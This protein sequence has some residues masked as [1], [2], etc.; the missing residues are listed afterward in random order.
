LTRTDD[1]SPQAL[2]AR[3]ARTGLLFGMAAYMWWGGMPLYFKLLAHVPALQVLAHRVVWSVVFLAIV[4][5]LQRRSGEVLAALRDRRVLLMLMGSTA[6]VAVNW[7]VFIWAVS[8]N[9]VIQAALGY[10][11]NPLVVTLMG[12]VF[13]REKLRP[14]QVVAVLLATIGVM[15]MAIGTG[16]V[17][18]ASLALALSFGLYG[19]I[20]KQTRV[21]PVPGLLVETILLLPIS[22][23]VIFFPITTGTTHAPYDP[24]TLVFLGLSGVITALPLIW[25]A[26]AASRLRFVTIGMLQYIA[27]TG[28][29]LLAVLLYDEPFTRT[30]AILFA[31]IWSAVALYTFDSVRAY[32]GRDKGKISQEDTKARPEP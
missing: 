29:F 1:L 28:Q 18:Y 21:K 13:L 2:Q 23:G 8:N 31:F 4:V 7:Y 27:P 17:P 14:A 20:R 16:V 5:A 30:H 10:Y 22:L 24:R 19:L 3:D 25:F 32:Q 6:S 26:A 12:V 15:N 9:Y 11:I